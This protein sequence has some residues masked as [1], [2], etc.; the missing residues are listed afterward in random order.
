LS[1]S[2]SRSG[3]RSARRIAQSERRLELADATGRRRRHRNHQ[4]PQSPSSN[5]SRRPRRRARRRHNPGGRGLHGRRSGRLRRSDRTWVG[6]CGFGERYRDRRRRHG[7]N[8]RRRRRRRHRRNRNGPRGRDRYRIFGVPVERHASE[9]SEDHDHDEQSR[10]QGHHRS[11][12]Q[13]RVETAFL[14]HRRGRF[15]SARR[16]SSRSLGVSGQR[17]RP[18]RRGPFYEH[19]GRL[20]GRAAARPNRVLGMVDD[21]G[22]AVGLRG[23]PRPVRARVREPGQ[24]QFDRIFLRPDRR[25]KRAGS[26]SG[27]R[28][29]HPNRLGRQLPH[30]S[31]RA[32]TR[33]RLI[34]PVVGCTG[35]TGFSRRCH[36]ARCAFFGARH[37]FGLACTRSAGLLRGGRAFGG[38]PLPLRGRWIDRPARSGVQRQRPAGPGSRRVGVVVLRSHLR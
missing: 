38:H 24:Q 12:D 8:N 7:R 29:D 9:R 36:E 17:D 3:S 35:C 31:G 23:G 6:L 18:G 5:E 14:G 37:G 1:G 4:R 28:Y 20:D 10:D 33:I 11:P 19:A 15:G 16:S 25:R 22:L 13:R 34:R 2:P 30:G 27:A 21:R 26:R 32:N